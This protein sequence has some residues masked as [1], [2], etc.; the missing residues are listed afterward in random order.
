M[1]APAA[2]SPDAAQ[3]IPLFELMA[4]IVN[5]DVVDIE[6]IA[7]A[8]PFAQRPPRDNNP[9]TTPT[10]TTG[11]A[12]LEACV[13]AAAKRGPYKDV[14]QYL[15]DNEIEMPGHSGRITR[16]E[17]INAFAVPGVAF[18]IALACTAFLDSRG[19]R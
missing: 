16:G 2:V 17:L 18:G 5:L 15:T 6:E 19:A 9:P 4:R 10:M 8:L 13:D 12:R 11:L 3:L 14:V 1:P 7:G